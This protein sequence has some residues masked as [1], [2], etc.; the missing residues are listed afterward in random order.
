MNIDSQ[1]PATSSH[2]ETDER[3]DVNVKFIGGS[4][5]GL[6]LIIVMALV[7]LNRFMSRMEEASNRKAASS[8]FPDESQIPPRPRLQPD[9]PLELAEFRKS[10]EQKL[11]HYAWVDR[12]TQIV[13]IP[14]DR[15]MHLLAE[16][17]I[18]QPE[19]P[20]DLPPTREAKP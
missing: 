20:L 4:A 19:G 11:M 10:E 6:I 8:H 2:P 17:G 12:K 16:R 7:G 15:A 1:N 3:S 18:P 14:I 13:R 9:P 5:L